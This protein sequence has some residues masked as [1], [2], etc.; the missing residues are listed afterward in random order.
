M[1]NI[2]KRWTKVAK[3]I[4]VGRKIVKVSYLTTKECKDHFGWYKDQ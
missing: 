4:L 1:D 3:D 2:T